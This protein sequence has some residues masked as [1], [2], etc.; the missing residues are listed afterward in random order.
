MWISN[1]ELINFKSYQHQVFEFPGPNSNKNIV[2][3]GGMN[4][5]GKTTILEALYLG[6]YGKDSITHLARA[7]IKGKTG[8]KAFLKKA[9]HGP[10]IENNQPYM[11]ISIQFNIS[12]QDGYL[13]SRKW[14]FSNTGDLDEEEVLIFKTDNNIKKMPLESETLEELLGEHFV[15]AHLAPFFFF[16]GEEAKRLAEQSKEEQLQLGMESLLGVVLIRGLHSTLKSFQMSK[17]QNIQTVDK[18]SLDQILTKINEL[19][20]EKSQLETA[21]T[22]ISEE[23]ALLNEDRTTVLERIIDLGGGGGEI[24]NISD[25]IQKQSMLNTSLSEKESLLEDYLCNKV[26]LNFLDKKIIE[27]FKNQIKSEEKYLSWQAELK[28]LEPKK[29]KLYSAFFDAEILSLSPPLTEELIDKLKAKLSDAWQS[30]FFP[31][32][33][34]SV[35]KILHHYLTEYDRKNL[36]NL[37]ESIKIGSE[38]IT[39]LLDSIN[40]MKNEIQR[41]EKLKNR[42]EGVNKDGLLQKLQEKH[43]NLNIKIRDNDQRLGALKRQNVATE[44]DLNNA[45]SSYERLERRYIESSPVTSVVN[46]AD[47]VCKM[48]DELIPSL[49]SL[50]LHQLETAVESIFKQLSHKKRVG[51]VSLLEDGSCRVIDDK[52]DVVA[53][54]KAAGENQMFATALL[55]GLAEV[56]GVSA[57]MVVDTPMGRLDSLH[58]DNIL[59]YWIATESRQIILLCQNTEIDRRYFEKI[60]ER[61]GKTYLL[62]TRELGPGIC[63]THAIENEYFGE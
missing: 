22:E 6:L 59:T 48:I 39:S 55:G 19:Q 31:P 9:I 41:L 17:L 61:V 40:S 49:Y 23:L 47:R 5:Y 50:K 2:L 27:S 56:S 30:L 62:K 15:P 42:I 21:M 51:K 29:S 13:I 3:I 38:N 54:D 10:A 35:S 14:F 20:V 37:L 33:E 34:G 24:A 25:I 8:Y 43:D 1:I 32:P 46:R 60:S 16:D 44:S 4:G 45:K 26:P 7:G 63:K 28:T 58:R 36:D 12:K 18:E 52:G 53:F 11:T 57:P